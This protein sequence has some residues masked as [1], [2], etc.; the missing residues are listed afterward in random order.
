M[1]QPVGL[2]SEK[3]RD[4]STNTF[5]GVVRA[6]AGFGGWGDKKGANDETLIAV[7]IYIL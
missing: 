6:E 3:V 1:R 4:L 7:H 5:P 2:V